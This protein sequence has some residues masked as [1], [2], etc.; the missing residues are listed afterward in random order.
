MMK[1]YRNQNNFTNRRLDLVRATKFSD[2]GQFQ[3][4]KLGYVRLS[5][6]YLTSWNLRRSHILS[7][8][9]NLMQFVSPKQSTKGKENKRSYH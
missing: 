3:Y 4:G 8:Q 2:R 1:T 5:R 9:M 7:I 6:F